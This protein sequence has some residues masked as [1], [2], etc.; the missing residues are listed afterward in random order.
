MAPIPSEL[1]DAASASAMRRLPGAD[2]ATPVH[3]GLD[4]PVEVSAMLVVAGAGFL[5]TYELDQRPLTI[6]RAAGCDIVID[7]PEL[8]RRHA[9]V[10]PGAPATV[11]DLGS[12]NGTRIAGAIR[13]GGPASPLSVSE[14]FHIGPFAFMVVARATGPERSMSMRDVLRVPDPTVAAVHGV[15]RSIAAGNANVLVLGETGVGK[16]V[17]AETLHELSGRPGP[18]IRINCA[19]LSESLLESELFGHEKG[20]FTGAATAKVGLLEGA[21]GGTVFLDEVGEL[22]LSIQAK[23]LRAVERHEVLRVGAVRVTPIDVR[24]VAA[25][26][27]DLGAEV[28]AGTFRRDL[29]FRLDGVTLVI[30]PLRER[31][32]MIGRLAL[33]FLRDV[34]R[35]AAIAG[36]APEVLAALEANDW[37]GNVRQLKAV[38][39]R[40]VLL[41]HGG[42]IRV[43]HLA[44]ARAAGS[45]PVLASA[46]APV[47]AVVVVDAPDFLDEEEQQDRERVIAALAACA[48]NQSRAAKQLGIGRTSLLQKLRL[49][50]IAR[51]RA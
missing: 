38:I 41:A 42:E 49:Y 45:A 25:T 51:P 46:P 36:L 35:G 44:F 18:L 10:T 47:P 31:R 21:A 7:H 40:A 22:P 29:F 16:E 4:A 26:N 5:S 28:E 6:G 14:T 50:R 39:E 2:E 33:G 8:S 23:L 20:S 43:K 12:T 30:P 15:V 9:V 1:I 24:F 3:P 11:L 32:G 48:G 13:R 17:L 37:P 19:A 27:R 34:Q